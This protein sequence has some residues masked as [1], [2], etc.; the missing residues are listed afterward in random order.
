MASGFYAAVPDLK[1]TCDAVRCAS[2]HVVFFWTFTGHDTDT[3]NP[4]KVAGWEEWDIGEDLKVQSS[5]GWFD[6]E[7][8]ARQIAGN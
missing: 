3:K 4:L 8:Y 2:D 6:A 5:R 7:D 1:L